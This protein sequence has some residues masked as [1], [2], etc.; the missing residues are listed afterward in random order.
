MLPAR[1]PQPEAGLPSARDASLGLLAA[2]ILPLEPL[3]VGIERLV[4]IDERIR[5]AIRLLAFV[6]WITHHSLPR[7]RRGCP[8]RGRPCQPR[9]WPSFPPASFS[10]FGWSRSSTPTWM[11]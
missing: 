6:S 1:P 11:R 5:L 7:P 10:V 8:M 9:P 4:L 3:L 2:K